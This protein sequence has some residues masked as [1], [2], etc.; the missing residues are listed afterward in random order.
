MEAQ[1]LQDIVG[2]IRSMNVTSKPNVKDVEPVAGFDLNAK[3]RDE[4]WKFIAENPVDEDIPQADQTDTDNTGNPPEGESSNTDNDDTDNTPAKDEKPKDKQAKK[5]K[6]IHVKA[7]GIER[8]CRAGD[9]FDQKGK[10]FSAD[11]I[12]DEQLEQL[13]ADPYLTVTTEG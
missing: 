4:A 1:R 10:T 9:C 13:M 6:T 5:A 3:E 7:K 12:S 2:A 11:E 8:R